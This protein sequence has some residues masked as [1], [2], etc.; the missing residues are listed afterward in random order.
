MESGLFVTGCITFR[1]ATLKSVLAW[2]ISLPKNGPKMEGVSLRDGHIAVSM[3]ATRILGF[4]RE[5]GTLRLL[6]SQPH[7]TSPERRQFP[8]SWLPFT[9]EHQLAEGGHGSHRQRQQSTWDCWGWGFHL[10]PST[11]P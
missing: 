8:S 3:T 5:M 9:L 11:A 6:G 10:R 1:R 2:P 7:Q 4:C